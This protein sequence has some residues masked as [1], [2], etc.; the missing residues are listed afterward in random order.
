[1]DVVR[2]R[3]PAETELRERLRRHGTPRLLVVADGDVPPDDIDVLEDWTRVG[4]PERDVA[5]RAL[6]LSLRAARLRPAPYFDGDG[7]LRCGRS[8]V[9]LS[10]LET[11]VATAL[12][13]RLGHLVDPQTIAQV[14]WPE[15]APTATTMTTAMRRLR[16]RVQHIGLVLTVVNS[17][18][19]VLDVRPAGGSDNSFPSGDERPAVTG[20]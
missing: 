15:G 2:L 1:M 3:W 6:T 18:G 7:L 14:G 4:A 16:D 10:P 8:F 11:R 9:A 5:A 17:K 13:H 19:W 20:A 12:V